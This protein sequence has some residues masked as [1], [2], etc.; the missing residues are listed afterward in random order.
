MTLTSA[1][2]EVGAATAAWA[3]F[4]GGTFAD[5]AIRVVVRPELRSGCDGRRKVQHRRTVC[6]SS[7]YGAWKIAGAIARIAGIRGLA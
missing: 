7:T 1:V 5:W 2:D 4:A 6:K 3:C